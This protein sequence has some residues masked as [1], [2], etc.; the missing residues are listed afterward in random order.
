MFGELIQCALVLA[1]RW[2]GGDF[3]GTLAH[4]HLPYKLSHLIL[5]GPLDITDP[6]SLMRGTEKPRG[7]FAQLTGSM[8]ATEAPLPHLVCKV[9]IEKTLVFFSPDAEG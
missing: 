7:L 2:G 4:W 9:L 8:G 6:I 3:E 1:G 5:G